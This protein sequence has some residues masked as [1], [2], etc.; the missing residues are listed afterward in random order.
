MEWKIIPFIGMGPVKFGMSPSEVSEIL[1]SPKNVTTRGETLREQRA[2]DMPMIRYINDKVT[3]IEAFYTVKNVT[4]DDVNIFE[5][6]GLEVLVDLE[7]KNEGAKVDVGIIMFENLGLT[8]GRLDEDVTGEHS[9][10]AFCGGHWDDYME[11]F[12]DISFQ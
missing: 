12:T 9:V 1:G 3:E 7:L 10:T 6:E 5:N 8:A 4:L 11:D 2:I